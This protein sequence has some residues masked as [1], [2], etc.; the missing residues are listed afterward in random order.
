MSK[1]GTNA[2]ASMASSNGSVGDHGLQFQDGWMIFINPLTVTI[3]TGR[4]GSFAYVIP[5]TWRGQ[6]MGT[7][8]FL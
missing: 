7:Y 5:T 1:H 2:V 3:L 8:C 4:F 6:V